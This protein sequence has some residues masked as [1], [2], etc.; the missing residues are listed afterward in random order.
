MKSVLFFVYYNNQS[1]IVPSEPPDA[2]YSYKIYVH[3]YF[4]ELTQ[5]T[6]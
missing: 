3:F 1:I 5:Y 2:K 6:D 4:E